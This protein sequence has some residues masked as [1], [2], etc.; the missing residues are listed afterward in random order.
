MPKFEVNEAQLAQLEGKVVVLTG[1]FHPFS[2]SLIPVYLHQLF[3][4]D[5]ERCAYYYKAVPM[6]L[7]DALSNPSMVWELMSF[8]ATS[9]RPQRPLW[10][11]N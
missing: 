10:L 4:E 8:S 1:T 9:T 5:F 2:C 7:V 3:L 11:R 6:E